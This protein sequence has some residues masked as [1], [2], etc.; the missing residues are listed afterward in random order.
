MSRILQVQPRTC[1]LIHVGRGC[2]V[3]LD[4]G[5]PQAGAKDVPFL[6]MIFVLQLLSKV[7]VDEVFVHYFERM[8]SASGSFA[9][10]PHRGL[11]LDH[12]GGLRPSD[13]L[14][15]GAH[16]LDSSPANLYQL[17]SARPNLWNSLSHLTNFSM[18]FTASVKGYKIIFAQSLNLVTS[19][20]PSFQTATVYLKSRTNLWCSDHCIMFFENL[21]QFGPFSSDN[22]W[23]EI[24]IKLDARCKQ[25]RVVVVVVEMS[26]I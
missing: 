14:I 7:S 10:D 23:W 24:W 18:Y 13:P 25:G 19:A 15:A 26:I 9:P 17:L 20:L 21:V 12:A 4:H 11:S 2:S 22:K 8:L 1:Q 16:G 5:R 3:S 6:E